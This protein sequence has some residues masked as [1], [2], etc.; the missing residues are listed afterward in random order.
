M[1]ILVTIC[2]RG[3]SKG[4]PD[5]NIKVINGLPLIA[6]SIL[7]ARQI[8]D[9][10]GA[11]IALSTDSAR[12]KDV[13]AEYGLK[14]EYTRPQDLATDG[15]GKIGVIRDVKEFEER[16][17]QKKYD[18]VIDLEVTSPLRNL[19]DIE[20]A[21]EKLIANE[22]AHIIVGVSPVTK[23][24]YYNMWEKK[25]DG[26]WGLSK[27]TSDNI[28]ARQKSPKVY[29][30]NGMLYIMRHTFFDYG[31][32]SIVTDK[33]EVYVSPHICFDLDEMIDF[34]FMDFVLSNNKLD[35]KLGFNE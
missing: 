15:A 25:E 14:A 27:P 30:S 28:L 18:Y 34:Y 32:K 33:T 26:F 17:R 35:F 21:L 10:Y 22:E 12:Y 3:G 4:I 5:K 6:Y 9:K 29:A 8:K 11:D 31:Y 20:V 16:K 2:A 7:L 13:A 24:P 1:E 19:D 23:N